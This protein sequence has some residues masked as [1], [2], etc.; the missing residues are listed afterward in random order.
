MATI[1][2]AVRLNDMM[3][4]PIRNI[5]NA[6]NMMLS[7]WQDLD[8]ATS[9]GLDIGEVESIRSELNKATQALDE[10]GDEQR[11][12]NQEVE[13]GSDALSSI[14]TKIAGMVGAFVGIQ[15]IVN[16]A[17][18]AIE[19]AS[20]LAEVQNVVDVAFGESAEVINAWSETTLEAFGLNELSA[21]QFAGTMGAMLKS[22]G[23]TGDA[24]TQM[25]MSIAELAGDMASFYNLDGTEAFNKLRAGISGETE[26]LKQLGINMSVANLEAYA[27]SQ[28]IET[29]YSEMS[30]A[31]QV[32]L[33]YQY[34]MQA[35]A[36]AQ[37]DFARTSNSFSNQQKLLTENWKAFTG[38]LA[39]GV[40]PVLTMALSALNSAISFTAENWSILQPILIGVA[41]ALALV[42]A[43]LLAQAALWLWN[44][45]LVPAYTAVV[46]FLSHGYNVLTN[47]TYRNSAAQLMY[48][49][50]LLACPLTWILLIIIA[51][52]AAIYAVI[53][54]INKVTGSTISATG[55]ILGALTAAVSV[56]WNLFLTLLSL[57]I[58]SVLVPLTNAWDQFANFFGNIFTDPIATIIRGFESLAN[59][60]LGI[61]KTIANGIDAIFGS[62]L[63]G[64]VQGWMDTVSGKADALVEKYGNGTYEE[65]SNL[66]GQLQGLLSDAQ[67]KFSWQTSDAYNT[68]YGWGESIEDKVSGFFG[69]GAFSIPE[70]T[71]SYEE[72]LA[73]MDG[74]PTFDELA[75][76]TG[77]IKDSLDI[78]NENLK[79][80][81][82]AAEQEVV[83][84]FTTAEIRVELGGVTN[85][86][87]QN[88]DLDGVMDY[89]VSATQEAMERVAEGVH[90]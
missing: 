40:L 33:R 88:T 49:N 4:A 76:N 16:T 8:S 46:G 3:S 58:Q 50:A 79:Y 84:R 38:E 26:P 11:E 41:A 47:A 19:F 36:D 52:I 39:G 25:S 61:L 35:T 6:M 24:V 89:F 87:N 37:G 9:G 48:N 63:A 83:N 54:V 1:Q 20:D 78:T 17:K 57:I 15:A 28:G 5:T 22:S 69:G 64:T 34:L 81:R 30:Q 82:D 66:T 23:L 21:K 18:E 71:E 31:Q 77:D 45:V 32:M 75:T 80:L 67:T 14:T 73:G 29:A 72:L 62:N 56:I 74:L 86:V 51:V 53:A 7:S 65:K 90:D 59:T 12:F 85:N 42:K 55:V 10:M 27:L 2:S 43:P 68:G 44:S 70:G 13:N 60:V